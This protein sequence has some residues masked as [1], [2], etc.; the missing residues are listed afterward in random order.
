LALTMV[1]A[2]AGCGGQGGSGKSGQAAGAQSSTASPS[3]EASV[4]PSDEAS[5][6]PK[7]L[8][9]ALGPAGSASPKPKKPSSPKPAPTRRPGKLVDLP[10]APKPAPLP[11]GTPC[12]YHEGTDA[13]RAA[14]KSAL[15][16]AAGTHFWSSVPITV[17]VDLMKAVAWQESGWQSTIMACDGGIGTMQL[18]PNTVKMMN[19]R[20]VDTYDAHTL[21]GNTMLGAEYLEWLIKSIGFNYFNSDYTV[22]PAACQD[23]KTPCMLNAVIASYNIGPG[24]V[25]NAGKLDIPK[26]VWQYV[27]N[28]RALMTGCACL[29]F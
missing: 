23:E 22:D 8:D 28:V 3:D 9:Q 12:P 27:G 14:V 29:A 25:D 2:V 11:K 15:V 26:S 4:L 24:G 21:T 13:S 16:T 20:F 19:D 7:V 5:P 10:P 17:P 6:S 18:M 1:V